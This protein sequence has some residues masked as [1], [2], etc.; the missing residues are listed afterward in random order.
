M[1]SELERVSLAGMDGP[2]AAR[3]TE[4]AARIQRAVETRA[5]QA[6]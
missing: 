4:L 1:W 6:G 3:F 2:D 5:D